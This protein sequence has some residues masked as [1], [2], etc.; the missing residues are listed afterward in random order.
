MPFKTLQDHMRLVRHALEY[1]LEHQEE[2][3]GGEEYYEEGK[4]AVDEA[5][6]TLQQAENSIEPEEDN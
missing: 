6:R 5:I 2:E 1:C 4:A 3:E